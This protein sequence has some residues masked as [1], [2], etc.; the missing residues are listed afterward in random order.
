MTRAAAVVPFEQAAAQVS[1]ASA[2]TVGKRQAEQLAIGAAI[3]FEAFYAGR[4]PEPAPAGTG[5]LIAKYRL[6]F[7]DQD[8]PQTS[9]PVAPAQRSAQVKAK[10]S[11]KY[12]GDGLP[13]CK[14][15]DLLDHLSTLDR[16]R[17]TFAGQRIEK[18]TKPTP[19]QRRA[20][21]LLGS[22]VPLTLQ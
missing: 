10:D 6:T 14:Y 21:E 4:R 7:T 8:I 5:L 17:V 22:P 20:F 12:N 18:L 19:V 15:Q 2:I 16:Q 11:S 9:D 3:D 1:A 13:I